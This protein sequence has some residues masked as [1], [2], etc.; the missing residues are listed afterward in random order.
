M[1]RREARG[2]LLGRLLDLIAIYQIKHEGAKR[3]APEGDE[4]FFA[5][6]QR[7]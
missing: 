5:L 3:K 4:A 6:L 7:R 1:S 2:T